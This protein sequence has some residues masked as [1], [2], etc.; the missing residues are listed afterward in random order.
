MKRLEYFLD[1]VIAVLVHDDLKDVRH[2]AFDDLELPAE[3]VLRLFNDFLDYPAA[4]AVEADKKELF[5][6]CFI[7]D[8]FLFFCADLHVLLYNIVSKFIIDEAMN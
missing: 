6:N 8:V 5:F 2:Q 3:F 4:I 1:D 7:D